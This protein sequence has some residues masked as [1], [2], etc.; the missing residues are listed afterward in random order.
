MVGAVMLAVLSIA[1][2]VVLNIVIWMVW[3]GRITGWRNKDRPLRWQISGWTW[4]SLAVLFTGAVTI[5]AVRSSD[6]S[7]LFA[8]IVAAMYAW[9]AYRDFQ[10]AKDSRRKADDA[11]QF[12]EHGDETEKPSCATKAPAPA[13]KRL[14]RLGK[15]FGYLAMV[16]I[17]IYVGELVKP[18]TWPKVFIGAAVLGALAGVAFIASKFFNGSRAQRLYS[19]SETLGMYALLCPVVYVIVSWRWWYVV[20]AVVLGVAILRFGYLVWKH[21][22]GDDDTTNNELENPF[23]ATS[24]ELAR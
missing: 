6:W 10:R 19:W 4:I 1:A 23:P 3:E 8:I 5:A 14:I 16:G 12:T 15:L 17:A 18:V 9:N 21:W 22:P 7:I 20:L 2:Y 24:E 11:H 13:M